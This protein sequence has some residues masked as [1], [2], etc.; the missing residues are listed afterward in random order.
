MRIITLPRPRR[1]PAL[2]WAGLVLV[3]ALA[4]SAARCGVPISRPHPRFG[5]PPAAPGVPAAGGPGGYPA[6]GEYP[7]PGQAPASPVLSPAAAGPG[8]AGGPVRAVDTERLLVALTFDVIWGEVVPKA[9][10]DRL[11]GAGVRATFFVSAPWAAAFPELVHYLRER[12]MEVGSFGY[13]AVNL[14]H[15]PGEDVRRDLRRAHAVLSGIL[16]SP[17]RLFRPPLGA[18]N[19]A[20]LTEAGAL[21][22]TV[23]GWRLD[24]HDWTRPGA[25]YVAARVLRR[26][27][28][29]DVVGFCASDACVQ[30]EAAVRAIVEGLQER[31]YVPLTV[32]ELLGAGPPR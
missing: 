5:D 2:R 15:R 24:S 31:S 7:P 26:V 6:F 13:E 11:A 16:N 22:Y 4:V 25:D 8:A 27:E 20:V 3:V 14:T 10:A 17:V 9:L 29:G 28:P 23:V 18:V 30:T 32:S 1:G 19:E 12:G 21:G